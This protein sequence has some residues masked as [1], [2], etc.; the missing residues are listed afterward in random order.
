[1]WILALA[2]F[3]GCKWLTF[4]RALLSGLHPTI[5][6]SLAYFFAW[7]G[8]DPRF[9]APRSSDGNGSSKRRLLFSILKTF[10]GAAI[11]WFA[12]RCAFGNTPLIAGWVGMFGVILFLHFGLFEI[13]SVVWRRSGVNA[14]PVM[15][16]PV[17][18]TSI[19]DFWSTRWNTAFNG[20]AHDLA[21]HPLARRLGVTRATIGV[22]L[23][24][25]IVHD[26]VI[27]LPAGAGFGLPTAYFLLQGAA[28]LIERSVLGR[29]F[30]LGTGF[31]GWLFTAV[32]AGGPAFWLFHPAFVKNVIV[33]MLHAIGAN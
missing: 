24:S 8:M 12:A 32:C 22:F 13:L 29:R 20:L 14:K 33:P 25:G 1:M 27:S 19:S 23:I 31:R 2:I 18:A 16:A 17:L 28:V 11:F 21:F 7:P 4:R 30:G 15:R 9:L 6:R 10:A 5:W 3:V 26:L